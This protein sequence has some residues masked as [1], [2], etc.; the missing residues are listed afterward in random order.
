MFLG[1]DLVH[2]SGAAAREKAALSR[3][4]RQFTTRVLHQREHPFLDRL[5]T[6]SDRL[7]TVPLPQVHILWALWAAKEAAFKAAVKSMPGIPFSPGSIRIEF[8][9]PPASPSHSWPLTERPTHNSIRPLAYGLAHVRDQVYEIL[10]DYH[11]DFVHALALG[12]R[13]GDGPQTGS[14]RQHDGRLQ[15]GDR[16][17]SDHWKRV[18]RKIARIP[19]DHASDAVRK[20]AL[21]LLRTSGTQ[22]RR[23]EI[24]R[25]VLANGRSGPP[26]FRDGAIR[27][28][29]DLTLTH[30]GPWGAAAI[31]RRSAATF[32]PR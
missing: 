16:P 19:S 8:L 5:Q 30:D 7:V 12:P 29:L 23:I 4:T 9:P 27:T 1:N 2:W 32:R 31:L 20:I 18:V 21:R 26:T 13:N 6:I 10:W 3:R 15:R 17:F 24:V 25:D 14:R 22:I 11:G 28:D